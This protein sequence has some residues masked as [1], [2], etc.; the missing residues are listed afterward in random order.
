MALVDGDP[1]PDVLPEGIDRSRAI[2]TRAEL[3]DLVERYRGD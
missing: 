2:A 1:P 3:T